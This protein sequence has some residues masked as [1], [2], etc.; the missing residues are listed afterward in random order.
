MPRHVSQGG[1]L[2][3]RHH[4]NSR[5][6]RYHPSPSRW[7]AYGD[8]GPRGGNRQAKTPNLKGESLKISQCQNGRIL[9]FFL[10]FSL[11]YSALVHFLSPTVWTSLLALV[12]KSITTE[13]VFLLF[14]SGANSQRASLEKDAFYYE[15][16]RGLAISRYRKRRTCRRS[17]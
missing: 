15:S 10:F 16:K 7:C 14:K 6:S 9:L 11:P 3:V 4:S 12:G 13:S 8:E 2:Y 5:V 17:I 1:R